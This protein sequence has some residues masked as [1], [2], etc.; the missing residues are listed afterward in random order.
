MGPGD[1]NRY[2]AVAHLCV[3]CE[4]VQIAARQDAKDHGQ[5]TPGLYWGVKHR[6]G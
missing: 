4:T 5:P 1:P 6:E 3:A 2:D